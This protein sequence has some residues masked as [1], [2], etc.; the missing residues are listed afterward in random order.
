ML[1][2]LC[3]PILGLAGFKAQASMAQAQASISRTR[4]DIG[5]SERDYA[6]RSSLAKSTAHI[7]SEA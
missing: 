7:R 5:T 4:S 1:D 6:R 3:M 2:L